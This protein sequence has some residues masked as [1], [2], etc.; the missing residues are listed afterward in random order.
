MPDPSPERLAE[1]SHFPRWPTHRLEAFSDGVIA[2]LITVMVFDLKFS[3]IPTELNLTV[4]WRVLIPKFIAFALS[5]LVLAI[6][7]VNHHQLLHTIRRADRG[8][9]WL[10]MH[11]LFWLSLIPFATHMIGT[12]PMLPAASCT[13]G[14]IFGMMAVS[15]FLLR[16]QAAKPSV[17]GI[18]PG[19]TRRRSRSMTRSYL[20]IG[21]YV[22]GAVLAYVSVWVSFALFAVV[23]AIFF[24][25]AQPVPDRQQ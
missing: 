8:L 1:H 21:F 7:W 2:I 23:P 24:L 4:E 16:I 19:R 12:N 20:S 3:R 18:S 22:A 5:F 10:N 25:P 14:L 13:Y 11:L 15:F 9:L 6:V 17:A